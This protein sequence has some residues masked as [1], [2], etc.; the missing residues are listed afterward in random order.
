MSLF[1]AAFDPSTY[2]LTYC[3]AGHTPPLLFRRNDGMDS[4][5][6]L[7]P[8]GAAIGL[9]ED[10][11]FSAETLQLA[12]GDVLLMCTDGVTEAIN[13][14]EELFGLERLTRLVHTAWDHSPRD[15][16]LEIR[17]ALG[18]FTAGLALEDD[19]TIVACKVIG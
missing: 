7:G 4:V 3:N 1:L 13:Q 9:V 10:V 16:I 2:T 18:E 11:P 8:T 15:L 14:K 6:L 19:V 5:R 17:Q 12:H